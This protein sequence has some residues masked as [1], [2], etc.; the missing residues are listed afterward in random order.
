MGYQQ[1]MQQEISVDAKKKTKKYRVKIWN[2][3]PYTLELSF[4]GGRGRPRRVFARS[5]VYKVTT[6]NMFLVFK[7]YISGKPTALWYSKKVEKIRID[8]E[9]VEFFNNST[10]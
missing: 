6:D 7:K 10:C 3:L 9:A 8:E 2:A 4:I 1:L 5:H